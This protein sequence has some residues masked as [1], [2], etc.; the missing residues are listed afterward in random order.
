MG[1]AAAVAAHGTFAGLMARHA[2]RFLWAGLALYW[3]VIFVLTHTPPPEAAEPPPYNDKVAHFFGYL[4][5]SGLLYLTLWINKP[6]WRRT[7]LLTI[8]IV[9]SYGVV[10]E[11]LQIP[12]RR[13]ASLDDWLT[14]AAGTFVAVGALTLIR[15]AVK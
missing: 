13:H 15:R 10:D 12:F 3:L 11:L 2:R 1:T 5:L 9:L 14:D 8:V 7:A 6:A 4:V